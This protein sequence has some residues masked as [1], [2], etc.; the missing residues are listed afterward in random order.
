MLRNQRFDEPSAHAKST[1]FAFR[2]AL[3]EALESV[4]LDATYE[5]SAGD[6]LWRRQGNVLTPVLDL[7]GGYGSNLFGHQH[8]ALVAYAKQL[9]DRNVTGFAQ[10]SVREGAERLA[11]ALVQRLGPY[12]VVFTNSGTE[13]VEAALKHAYLERK[14]PLFWSIKGAF[15]GKTLGSI[16]LT[17]R[18]HD[19]FEGLGPSVRFLDPHDP[20]AWERAEKDAPDVAAVFIEP[21]QGEG[22]VHVLPRPFV[23]WLR[24]CCGRHGIPIVSDE[25]QTGMGRTGTFLGCE[26]LGLDPDY[27]C[28]GKAL[29]GGIAKIG[30]LLVRLERFQ[31]RF[32]MLHSSTF[33]EDDWS[34]MIALKA[35]E[36]V[37]EDELPARCAEKGGYLLDRLHRIQQSFPQQIRDVRG[38]GLMLGVELEPQTESTSGF[39]E[40]LSGQCDL[41]YFAAG[42]LLNVHKI[43]VMP[44]LSSPMT[45]RVEPSAYIE[46]ENLD[47][48]L[49]ALSLYARASDAGD[50]PHLA[51]HRLGLPEGRIKDYAGRR[52]AKRDAPATPLRVA[53]IGHL[54]HAGDAIGFDPSL[55]ALS[56]SELES[57]FEKSARLLE[58]T[59]LHRENVFSSSGGAVH[60]SVIGLCMTA[61]QMMNAWRD[62]DWAWIR[63]KINDAVALARDDGCQVVGLGGHTSI[64]T[65]NCRWLQVDGIALTSGNSLTAG[66]GI[67]ALKRAASVQ[68]IELSGARLAVTGAVGNIASTCAEMLAPEV[69]SI[70]LI[71]RD[72]NSGRVARLAKK[73]GHAAS[74][75]HIE[76]TESVSAARDCSLIVTASNAAEALIQP[77]YLAPGPVAICDLAI[78]PDVGAAVHAARPDVL[79]VQGGV[80]RLP[81]NDS[82]RIPGFSI[83]KGHVFACMAETMLMGL[84]GVR[85]HGSY[86][87]ITPD[88]VCKALSLADKHGFG[89]QAADTR[90]VYA[91]IGK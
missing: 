58:P 42:Y 19:L 26:H 9:F 79:T 23:D 32:S 29:G 14:R 86:G 84:E 27:I 7:V 21:I 90:R 17:W 36:I 65:G 33:A 89:L 83:A 69:K 12:A 80:V 5:R 64:L 40:I 63:S 13:T 3:V 61:R 48:F 41:G 35:L 78:P 91:E 54:A 51:R 62:G 56:L 50:L 2:S 43:R 34:C 28:L 77:E 76:V 45:I 39:L 68:G 24:A 72:T 46:Q 71:V 31:R 74:H 47:R 22:G 88:D 67:R 75:V 38:K 60:L 16:Q 8:P 10:G 66:M 73:I 53:F 18:D 20:A 49:D 37:D 1:R 70:V 81:H 57:L 6:F 55:G 59:I 11:D 82:F 87:P 85:S 30:A 52:A 25:I 44:T 4:G 15:H